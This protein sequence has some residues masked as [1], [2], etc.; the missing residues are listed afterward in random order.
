MKENSFITTW[1][2]KVVRHINNLLYVLCCF[3][4]ISTKMSAAYLIVTFR[5]NILVL[6]RYKDENFGLEPTNNIK[7]RYAGIQIVGSIDQHVSWNK[8]AVILCD[9]SAYPVPVFR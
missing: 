2:L 9:V 7:P 6:L 4:F 1:V 5:Q 8:T 3:D